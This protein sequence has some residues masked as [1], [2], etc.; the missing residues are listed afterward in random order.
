MVGVG[1]LFFIISIGA[2][3]VGASDSAQMQTAETQRAIA[4]L[5]V[6]FAIP[7]VQGVTHLVMED[8]NLGT[9]EQL[10]LSPMGLHLIAIFRDIGA[11]LAFVPTAILLIGVVRIA[12]G[13]TISLPYIVII[14]E[15]LL[16]RV[17]M[18]GMGF[19]LGALALVFKRTGAVVN[20]VCIGLFVV[21]LTPAESLPSWAATLS[22]LLPLAR[23]MAAIS[24]YMESG[25]VC[26]LQ[27]IT[28]LALST[29]Y[30]ALGVTVFTVGQRVALDRGLMGKC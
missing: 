30:A 25:N 18:L 10:C 20:L 29:F 27:T 17:G 3:A 2:R 16:M 23:S 5:M 13:L 11:V 19:A 24:G 12:S 4:Y 26:L 28:S 9:L 6:W 1:L 8:S 22:R 14:G 21:S 15:A 7:A